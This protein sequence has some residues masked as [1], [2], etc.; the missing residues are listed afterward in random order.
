MEFFNLSIGS[1]T[2]YTDNV[3]D[4]NPI[5][6][7]TFKGIPNANFPI[8]RSTD[9]EPFFFRIELHTGHCET[10]GHM[11]IHGFLLSLSVISSYHNHCEETH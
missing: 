3:F 11:F 10:H 2:Y 8:Y 1:V 6:N 4:I 9:E 5:H 7:P